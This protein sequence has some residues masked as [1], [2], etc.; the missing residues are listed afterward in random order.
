MSLPDI[1]RSEA[2]FIPDTKNNRIVYSLSTVVAVSENILQQVLAKRPFKSFQDFLDRMDGVTESQTIG[3]IKAGCFDS[4]EPIGR[5]ALLIRYVR[6]CAEKA[7]PVKANLT[8]TQLKKAIEIGM[9]FPAEHQKE[10]WMANFKK[11]IKANQTDPASGG[12][13]YHLTDRDALNFFWEFL[14]P[15]LNPAKGEWENGPN[16]SVYMKASSF[17]REYKK[18]M[19]SLMEYFNSQK[20]RE[21][22]AE[23]Q[24]KVYRNN[25]WSKYC[26]GTPAQWEMEQLSFYHE[27]HELAG[28]NR[29]LYGISDFKD[30]PETPEMESYVDRKGMTRTVQKTTAIAGTVV[31]ADNLKHIVKLL[32]TTGVVDV[33][34]YAGMYNEYKQTISV[35]DPKTKVKTVIDQPWLKRGVKLLVY[36]FRREESFVVR[37][38]MVNGYPRSICRIDGVGGDGTADLKFKRITELDA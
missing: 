34:L 32:T 9:E 23:A 12:K 18:S 2:D 11:W 3:M 33:K 26:V 29:S 10:I 15:K 25:L 4:L 7:I 1:N 6:Q 13:R 21:A 16:G 38:K 27:P 36:G 28:L 30:L 35:I 24:R 31:H 37:K 8:D 17:D 19:A 14:Y 5:R 20:A 22:F